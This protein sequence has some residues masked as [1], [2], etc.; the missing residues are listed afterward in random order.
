MA[1]FLDI[2]ARD[3]LRLPPAGEVRIKPGTVSAGLMISVCLLSGVV[4]R[5]GKEQR[6]ELGTGR[7]L[8][9]DS[10]QSPNFPADV[11]IEIHH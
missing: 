8:S 2:H 10:R 6:I 11:D 7:A 4:A 3:G 1:Y 9:A 5:S